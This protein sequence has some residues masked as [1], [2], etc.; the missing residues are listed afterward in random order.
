MQTRRRLPPAEVSEP[1]PPPSPGP[2]GRGTPLP[3]PPYP[4]RGPAG[5]HGG[6][7]RLSR[8]GST[9]A[10]G[11]GTQRL[12]VPPRPA[13]LVP[14]VQPRGRAPRRGEGSDPPSALRAPN[15]LSPLSL[16]A[17]RR[18]TP[19]PARPLEEDRP[20][21]SA[22]SPGPP[23]CAGARLSPAAPGLAERPAAR[24]EGRIPACILCPFFGRIRAL[25]PGA[26][27]DLLIAMCNK[28]LLQW[29]WWWWG[30]WGQ[31]AGMRFVTS[32]IKRNCG[33][34]S[35]RE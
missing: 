5:G 12:R 29:W 33:H 13:A 26:E 27:C 24:G 28:S 3:R 1:S 18:P 23:P 15:R 19:P 21:G 8:A 20:A 14:R 9:G 34:V 25:S 32:L 6:L 7:R 16:G 31:R 35:L 4:E 2:G 11:G 10:G 22:A 17:A 30:G